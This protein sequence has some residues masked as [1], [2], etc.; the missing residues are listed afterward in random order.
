MTE[1][2]TIILLQNL[3]VDRSKSGD[4][5]QYFKQYYIYILISSC[6]FATTQQN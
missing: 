2:A 5:T 3:F 6:G 4:S 1:T